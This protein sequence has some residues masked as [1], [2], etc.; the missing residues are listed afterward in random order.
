MKRMIKNLKKGFTLVELVVV[1]AIIAIL[2]GVSVAVYAGITENAQQSAANQ[3]AT[4]VATVVRAAVLM[5]ADGYD[6]EGVKATWDAE[7]GIHFVGTTTKTDAELLVAIYTTAEGALPEGATIAEVTTEAAEAKDGY[8]K[9]ATYTAAN[10]K[11]AT[12]NF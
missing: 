10:G 12:M 9:V 2:S 4:T 11:S 3:E 1:I 5:D 6:V 7:K 8:I